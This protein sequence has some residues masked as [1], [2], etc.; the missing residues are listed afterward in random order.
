MLENIVNMA[1]ERLISRIIEE[2]LW[3]FE[4]DACERVAEQAVE[5]VME[6]LMMPSMMD[7]LQLNP[8][9]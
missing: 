2:I 8:R 9:E 5:A 6:G 1:E 7:N 3:L 4:Y